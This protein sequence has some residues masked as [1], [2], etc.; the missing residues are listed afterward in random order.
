MCR[1]SIDMYSSVMT[2]PSLPSLTFIR[3]RGA[4]FSS[5]SSFVKWQQSPDVNSSQLMSSRLLA[6]ETSNLDKEGPAAASSPPAL[7]ARF[8]VTELPPPK[9][10]S[11]SFSQAVVNGNINGLLFFSS[12][13]LQ[14]LC[15]II[16]SCK[17]SD[18]FVA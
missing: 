13:W 14:T 2:P 15:S 12:F 5:L 6:E 1:Q 16:F 11:C 17:I 9:E 7:S 10:H 4:S 3:S 18:M 8:S